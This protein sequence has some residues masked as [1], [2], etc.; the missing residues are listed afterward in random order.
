[1]NWHIILTRKCNLNCRYCGEGEGISEKRRIEYRIEDLTAFLDKDKSDRLVINFYGGEPTLEPELM[2]KI[3]RAF[4]QASFMLQTNGTGIANLS[5]FVLTRLHSVLI[6][7]DGREEVTDANRGKGTYRKAL[8]GARDARRR[9]FAG[10]LIAR[11]AVSKES[12]IYKEVKH[13]LSLTDPK[14]DYV[15]WQLNAFWHEDNLYDTVGGFK[16]W[17]NSIY[18]PG[19]ARLVEEWVQ[20][21]ERGQM[22]G[23]A[24]FIPLMRTLLTGQKASLWCGSGR[25]TFSIEVDGSI[26]TCPISPDIM[27]LK[28]GHIRTTV[29][30]ALRNIGPVGGPCVSCEV[31]SVCGGRCLFAN[32]FFSK[33]PDF[34]E[35]CSSV[36]FL[37]QCLKEREGRVRAAMRTGKIDFNALE[38]PLLNNGCEIVP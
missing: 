19:I 30:E 14:F 37:I 3:A 18:N 10:D 16:A 27:E 17:L 6:S 28:V 29:P 22:S 7:I 23:I 13:V 4:P 26:Y 25:D 11:F 36:K 38:W 32:R 21:I 5:E 34:E 24:P 20:S 8:E 15:H 2:E 12:D 33:H 9:G 1:M 31:F 35:V